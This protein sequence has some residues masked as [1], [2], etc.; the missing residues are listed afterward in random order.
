MEVLTTSNDWS[1][2][3][4][5]YQQ[6]SQQWLSPKGRTHTHYQ[7]RRSVYAEDIHILAAHC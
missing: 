3:A 7:I 6:R 4:L 1:E 5:V 2:Y